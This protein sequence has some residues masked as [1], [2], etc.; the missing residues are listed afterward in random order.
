MVPRVALRQMMYEIEVTNFYSFPG[1]A[2]ISIWALYKLW[3]LPRRPR[4]GRHGG[5]AQT[6]TTACWF[7]KK[8]LK[9]TVLKTHG[10]RSGWSTPPLVC[11]IEALRC[12][13]RCFVCCW[14]HGEWRLRFWQLQL[15]DLGSHWRCQA[16][17]AKGRGC[18]T[19]CSFGNGMLVKMEWKSGVV[20]RV[21]WT[22]NQPIAFRSLKPKVLSGTFLIWYEILF[23]FEKSCLKSPIFFPNGTS[24]LMEPHHDHHDQ[25]VIRVV[26]GIS[27]SLWEWQVMELWEGWSQLLP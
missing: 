23:H 16:C 21:I 17:R 8:H 27:D 2:V 19:C 20:D 22:D 9:K 3:P 24:T 26:Y 14:G 1:T 4:F 10:M 6:P 18:F 15:T 11:R 13:C 12:R 25:V 7:N 5:E